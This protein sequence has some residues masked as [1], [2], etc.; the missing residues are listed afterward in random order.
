[1]RFREPMAPGFCVLRPF[2]RYLRSRRYGLDP[3]S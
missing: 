1:M 2:R 3:A